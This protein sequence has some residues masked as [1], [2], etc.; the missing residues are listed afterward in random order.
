[1]ENTNGQTAPTFN[2]AKVRQKARSFVEERMA[3]FDSSHDFKHVQRVV[4]Q[5][6]RIAQEEAKDRGVHYDLA[7]VEL[8]ALLHDVGD[9]KYLS[10]DELG[11]EMAQNF[12][13]A[14]Q[15]PEELATKVQTIVNA[16]SYSNEIGNLD[17]VARV[18]AKHPE[19]GPVQ[20]ADR[21]D[22]LGAIGIARCL[23]FHAARSAKTESMTSKN[24]TAPPN[25]MASA[26]A[27]MGDKLVKVKGMM[28]TESGKNM[29]RE[30]TRRIQEYMHWFHEEFYYDEEDVEATA[31]IGS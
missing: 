27:H 12:L 14:A 13:R 6:S 15:A 22:A 4:R 7:V 11:E 23:T 8:A 3:R 30:K 5:A 25:S 28:K 16:V 24:D 31:L 20:D 19:L 1:M 18:L 9:H 2:L 26:V 29:A 10:G 21:L 17:H